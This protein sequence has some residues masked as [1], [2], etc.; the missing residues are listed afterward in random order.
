MKNLLKRVFMLGIMT[1]LLLSK[2]VVSFAMEMDATNI[3]SA[4]SENTIIENEV[5][6]EV[7][8]NFTGEITSEMRE[9]GVISLEKFF[10]IGDTIMYL[11]RIE[12][13]PDDVIEKLQEM[14]DINSAEYNQLAFTTEGEIN[15]DSSSIEDEILIEVESDF[16]GE[17]TAEMKELGIISL[18]KIFDE[19]DVTMYL[20][21]IENT[22]NDVLEKLK[23]LP[24]VKAAEYN[25]L[26]SA[27]QD[28]NTTPVAISKKGIFL[29]MLI[30]VSIVAV[31][32]IKIAIL[33][34]QR[35]Q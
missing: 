11:V 8:S 21:K 15:I 18:E 33:S 3:S 16:N 34:K 23:V 28:N 10:D 9:L 32:V 35:T 7:N 22:S 20:A 13:A 31:V 14:S 2:G 26:V 4:T 25:Q 30:A 27:Y 29:P 1:A 12:N 19:G 24:Q 6:I 5:I 17:I